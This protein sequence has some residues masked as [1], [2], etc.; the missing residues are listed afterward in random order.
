MEQAA[1]LITDCCQPSVDVLSFFSSLPKAFPVDRTDQQRSPPY[2]F[3][4]GTEMFSSSVSD[5]IN[6]AQ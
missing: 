6:L 5:A 4:R 2:F 3:V 1:L